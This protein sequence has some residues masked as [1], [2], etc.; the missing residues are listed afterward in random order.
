M[1]GNEAGVRRSLTVAGRRLHF[2]QHTVTP[3]VQ[4]TRPPLLLIHGAGGNYLQWPPRLRRLPATSVYA[5]DLPGHGKSP[6]PG[7]ATVEEYGAV[8]RAFVAALGL[9]APLVAGHSLGAAIALAYAHTHPQATAGLALV[10]GGPRLPV[11]PKLLALLETD[12]D[13][14][15]ERIVAG[16]YGPETPAPTRARSLAALRACAP[17]VLLGDFA[18]CARF[19]M[20]AALPAIQTPALV[21]CGDNDRMVAPALSAELAAG[22]PDSQLVMLRGAGHMLMVERTAQMTAIFADF[23]ERWGHWV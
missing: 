16:F 1:A 21:V 11:S 20:T 12:P 22:L 6:G 3:D 19:D 17:G 5:L 13:R 2:F 23:L 10:G 18:A 9:T 4:G 14:A 15:A 7:C 8:V